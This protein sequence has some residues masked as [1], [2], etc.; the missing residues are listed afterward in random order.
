MLFKK[1]GEKASSYPINYVAID[2]Q[3]PSLANHKANHI[4]AGSALTPARIIDRGKPIDGALPSKDKF[5]FLQPDIY[6]S[7]LSRLVFPF[8]PR[9]KVSL[10]KDIATHYTKGLRINLSHDLVIN[11]VAKN[12]KIT[13]ANFA[14]IAAFKADNSLQLQIFHFQKS[15]IFLALKH[16][17]EKKLTNLY[18][19][20]A[21][22]QICSDVRSEYNL[23]KIIL[24]GNGYE[25][26]SE[27]SPDLLAIGDEPFQ[28]TNSSEVF[29]NTGNGALSYLLPAATI[30]ISLA[31]Y[32]G[33]SFLQNLTLDSSKR[34][35]TEVVQGVEE[36]VN[37]G[38]AAS[39]ETLQNRQYY[40]EMRSEP[41]PHEERIASILSSVYQVRK[42][43]PAT[44]A[45]LVKLQYSRDRSLRGIT[46]NYDFIAT[47][48]IISPQ[49]SHVGD[50][51]NAVTT[52][53]GSLLG[54]NLDSVNKPS[55]TAVDNSKESSSVTYQVAG[56]FE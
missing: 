1:T 30:I 43:I 21:L 55:I 17:K 20:N 13:G 28:T 26:S 10:H 46:G 52:K 29:I 19:S 31:T 49:G 8:G 35:Y 56:V 37:N 47:I 34:K 41:T 9:L 40:M 38:A 24:C 44:N 50:L 22:A 51:L 7:I 23:S 42:D 48:T 33:A 27:K 15:G 45:T 18:V 2:S 25:P 54:I 36:I 3:L 11:W 12:R 53:I 32:L 39:I 14:V 4:I 16:F 6:G 5:P